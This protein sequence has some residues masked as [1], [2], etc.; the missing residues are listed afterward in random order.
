MYLLI[1]VFLYFVCTFSGGGKKDSW[2]NIEETGEFVVNIISD[3][4]VESANYTSGD[5]PFEVDEMEAS[6]LTPAA[7]IKV[8]PNRV[9]QSAVQME[10]KTSHVQHIYNDAGEHTCAVVFGRVVMFHVVEPLLQ[11]TARGAHEVKF[12]GY[13][14]VGRLGGDTWTE[15]GAKFDISRPSIQK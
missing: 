4:M 6:G 10:C 5:F 1:F 2:R 13:N 12:D 3:W 8:K 11:T 7:S 9:K 14:P 15:L